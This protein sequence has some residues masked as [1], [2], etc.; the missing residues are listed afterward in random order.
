[1]PTRHVV[2][3]LSRRQ[4]FHHPQRHDLLL[5]YPHQFLHQDLLGQHYLVPE[6]VD[7]SESFVAVVVVAAAAA[8]VAV[9]VAAALPRVVSAFP[10]SSSLPIPWVYHWANFVH[11]A[12]WS[13]IQTQ[14]P[15]PRLG[16]GILLNLIVPYAD[17]RRGNQE[18]HHYY[19]YY[20]CWH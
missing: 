14:M 18:R 20:R 11:R 1:M 2:L 17:P 10:P 12:S 9:V 6:V 13:I 8:T 7:Y 5:V 3:P 16:R 15:R 19:R 4:S